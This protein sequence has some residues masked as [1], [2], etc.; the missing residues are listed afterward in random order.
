MLRKSK[1]SSCDVIYYQSQDE[2]LCGVFC[3]QKGK[4]A[5]DLRALAEKLGFKEFDGFRGDTNIL[6]TKW[7]Y[8][9]S[10]NWNTRESGPIDWGYM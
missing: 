5:S 4:V 9:L 1:V 7:A 6:P 10:Y 2:Q 3:R 8:A